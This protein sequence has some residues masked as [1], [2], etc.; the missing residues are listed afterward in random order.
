M[1]CNV[2]KWM[3]MWLGGVFVGEMHSLKNDVHRLRLE[4]RDRTKAVGKSVNQLQESVYMSV[5]CVCVTP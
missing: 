5:L 1:F 3:W 4:L 2:H